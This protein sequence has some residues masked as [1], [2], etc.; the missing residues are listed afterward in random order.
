MPRQMFVHGIVQNFRDAMMQRALVRAADI[1]AGFF[2]DRLQTLQLA[3][4]GS[5]VIAVGNPVRRR[6]F[7][8]RWIRNT[9]HNFCAIPDK[10]GCGNEYVKHKKIRRI[11]QRE[12]AAFLGKK[13]HYSWWFLLACQT[14]YGV[15]KRAIFS[16][17]KSGHAVRY[18]VQT[19]FFN[20]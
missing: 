5:V 18:H 2:A 19:A 11:S 13:H 4:L 3:Q 15:V 6:D 1:H 8:L 12:T 17:P 14:S 20:R 9:R 10:F 16:G 7:F